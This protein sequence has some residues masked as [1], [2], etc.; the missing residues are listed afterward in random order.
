MACSVLELFRESVGCVE[1][2]AT[3]L[4]LALG[5]KDGEVVIVFSSCRN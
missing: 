2:R 4:Y 5:A 1:G 3:E